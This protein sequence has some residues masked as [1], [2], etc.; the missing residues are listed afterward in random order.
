[1]N[2]EIRGHTAVGRRALFLTLL[3]G[4][5]ALL[6][7]MGGR[8]AGGEKE[9]F[10]SLAFATGRI[11][12][13]WAIGFILLQGITSARFRRLDEAFGYDQLIKFHRYSAVAALF[14]A[15]LHP[16]LFMSAGLRLPESDDLLIWPIAVGGFALLG[17]W[18]V[19]ISSQCRG[20]LL[21]RWE[22]WR[23]LHIFAI[24]VALAALT[25]LFAI[26]PDLR[27]GW[28]LPVWI[29]LLFLWFSAVCW[30][31]LIRP[32]V[33][34]EQHHYHIQTIRPVAED[35]TEITLCRE[36]GQPVF[37]YLPG[38]FLFI[39][40][41]SGTVPAEE[42]PFTI[43]SSPKDRST[44]Q[45]AVKHCGDFTHQLNRLQP[46]DPAIVSGPHGGFSPWRLGEVDHLILIAGGIGITPMLSILRTL[47]QQENSLRVKLLWSNR[48]YDDVPYRDE[49]DHLREHCPQLSITHII[50]RGE[51]S[52]LY[53]N[54]RLDESMLRE[55]CPDWAAGTH[56]MLCGPEAMTRDLI[57]AFKTRGY[58]ARALHSEL[59]AL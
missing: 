30:A 23:G 16:I 24:P 39:R 2:A 17:L 42:H 7:V 53:R 59:F 57:K 13:L 41:T 8:D 58:P 12:G 47:A 50:T 18:V 54:G 45:L 32:R 36:D 27:S 35:I 38:Q 44:L 33:M 48:T 40:F 56:V 55:L 6:A 21:L 29:I 20:F 4:L 1:M 9:L 51:E 14:L 46:G 3:G 28:P 5:M 19:L 43:S 15:F 49:L 37:D 34:A 22:V 11:A 25:H 26:S 10:G 52:P 31:R